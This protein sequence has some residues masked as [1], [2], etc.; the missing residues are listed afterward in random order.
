MAAQGGYNTV[1]EQFG[2]NEVSR[3][4]AY[5]ARIVNVITTDGPS[6]A[7]WDSLLGA[8]G[9]NDAEV[10]GTFS[11][12]NGGDRDEKHGVSPGCGGG[13]LSQA[14]DLNGVG[15]H[16]EGTIRAFAK[17]GVFGEFPSVWIECVAMHGSMVEGGLSGEHWVARLARSRHDQRGRRRVRVCMGAVSTEGTGSRNLVQLSVVTVSLSGR[18]S[19]GVAVGVEGW[20]DGPGGG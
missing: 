5:I 9:T 1:E 14:V 7:V 2:S 4:G 17:G 11:W 12:G 13:S 6:D 15:L 20:S 16:P 8:V 3:L 10:S 18:G 19:D